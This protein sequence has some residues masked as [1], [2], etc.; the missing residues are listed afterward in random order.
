MEENFNGFEELEFDEATLKLLVKK[1]RSKIIG[2][3]LT[4]VFTLIIVA[5]SFLVFSE[6]LDIVNSVKEAESFKANQQYDYALNSYNE[7]EKKAENNIMTALGNKAFMD[8]IEMHEKVFGPVSCKELL[9]EYYP[10]GKYPQFAISYLENA[11]VYKEAFNELNNLL[12]NDAKDYVEA[13]EGIEK[14]GTRNPQYPKYVLLYFHLLATQKFEEGAKTQLAAYKALEKEA[15]DATWLYEYEGTRTLIHA[16][17][18]TSAFRLC[19][20]PVNEEAQMMRVSII[21]L[22]GEHKEA[23]M[24]CD[25]FYDYNEPSE[26]LDREKLIIYL[27]KGDARSGIDFMSRYVTNL[28][29]CKTTKMLYTLQIAAIKAN[30]SKLDNAITKYLKDKKLPASET[31]AKYRSGDLT[32]SEIFSDGGSDL[33]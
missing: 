21:R 15:P 30:D 26:L 3:V 9:D 13:Y 14:I 33:S 4:A 10:D 23:L 12:I 1:Y 5:F 31:V 17:E 18:L 27:I 22:M 32:I 11:K 25:E 7:A 2:S 19:P 24:L 16:N 20:E 28:S 8:K 29:N 6:N